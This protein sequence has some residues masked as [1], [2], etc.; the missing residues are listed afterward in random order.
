LLAVG[1]GLFIL[2]LVL[3]WFGPWIAD[4]IDGRGR[5]VAAR[6]DAV[7]AAS[8]PATAE[9][10]DEHAGAA[11][12]DTPGWI[13]RAFLSGHRGLAAMRRRQARPELT[14]LEIRRHA[15]EGYFAGV[16]KRFRELIGPQ[17]GMLLLG[18]LG[19]GWPMV[20]GMALFKSGFLVGAWS[21]REYG[22]W[23]A[24]LF[25][26]GLAATWCALM[27]SLGGASFPVRLRLVLPLELAGSFA[28]A[29]SYAAALLWAWKGNRLGILERP[30]V[31][32]GRMALSNYLCQTL[33]CTLLF[34]GF[35]LGLYGTL[36]RTALAAIV[37]TIWLVQ[38][39]WSPWWLSRF[40][41]GPV[42]WAWRSL[43][44]WERLPLRRIP[45]T[46]PP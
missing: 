11:A 40:R 30:L 10:G 37:G 44:A 20:I 4:W 46:C 22:L 17:A 6:V 7:L 28:L 14:T 39:A 31:A 41:L 18:F 21:T 27:V 12:S 24:A 38:L 13:D 16:T 43:A 19:L 36:P 2:P 1:V 35:G 15:E 29:L 9:D 25:A 3:A 23:A 5:A 42:E 26:A 45:G 8:A 33:V 34:A 32:A